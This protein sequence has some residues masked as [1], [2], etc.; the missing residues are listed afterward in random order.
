M[1]IISLPYV[2]QVQHSTV[3]RPAHTVYLCVLCGSQNK[4]RLFHYTA[5]T[6]WFLGAFV[7]LRKVTINFVMSVRPSVRMEQL[8]S[9]WAD[10]HE[11]LYLNIFRKI[12]EKIQVSLE[13]VNNN[14][15]LT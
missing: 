15:Y 4:Q 1:W 3:L 7:K 9:N 5:L 11:I 14:R 12:V 6:D 8:S 10:F 13:S 2:P